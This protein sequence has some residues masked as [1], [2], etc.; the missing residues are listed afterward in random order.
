MIRGYSIKL[1]DLGSI[2]S[3]SKGRWTRK[4]MLVS[5]D[6]LRDDWEVAR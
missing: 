6:I 5:K 1:N 3:Y 2:V 4:N